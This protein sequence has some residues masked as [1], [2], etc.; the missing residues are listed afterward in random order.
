M[1][2]FLILLLFKYFL[3]RNF[4]DV[5]KFKIGTALENTHGK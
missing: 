2:T 1:D 5:L 4:I 3:E